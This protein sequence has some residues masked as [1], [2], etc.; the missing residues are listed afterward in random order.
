MYII[1]TWHTNY[2]LLR[3]GIILF[4]EY[5]LAEEIW[6]GVYTRC[7]VPGLFIAGIPSC[8]VYQACERQ[9]SFI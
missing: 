3:L 5:A 1:A 2:L 6:H 8:S 4:V 7:G 9:I